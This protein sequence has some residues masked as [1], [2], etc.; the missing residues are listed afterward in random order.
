MELK[1]EK[2]PNKK[3]ILSFVNALKRTFYPF[4]F[5]RN[6]DSSEELKKAKYFYERYISKDKNEEFFANVD[7]LKDLFDKDI[8]AIFDG[9]PA[10][11]SYSEIIS[12]YPGFTAIFY[13]R[14]AH[15][16]YKQNLKI[17]ARIISEEAHFLTG[18]DIHPGA[19]IGE[20]FMIDHG[21]GI[22]IGETTIIGNNVRIY[23]GVTLGALSLSRGHQLKNTKRHP[24]IGNNVIIYSGASILGGESI[25]G[26]NSV[27]GSNVFI[28]ESIPENTLVTIN[29][30]DLI[31]IK[32]DKK[33]N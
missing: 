8:K 9:D 23:Q 13:H 33:E 12:A 28:T 20:F 16:I 31:C 11:D 7:T 26:D 5:A 15:I 14:I 30:P 17:I 21:T 6:I 3:G 10:A 24:T 4:L 32:K 18:I 2:I 1:N 22:V 27:I 29:K 19:K 25:I